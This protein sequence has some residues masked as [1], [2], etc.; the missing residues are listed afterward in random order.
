[1]EEF[2]D[3]EVAA[4]AEEEEAEGGDENDG[5]NDIHYPEN[6]VVQDAQLKVLALPSE[7][8]DQPPWL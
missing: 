8:R 4:A 2:E 5:L 7:R 6:D 1:M 3:S